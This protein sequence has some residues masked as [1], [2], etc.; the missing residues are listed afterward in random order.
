MTELPQRNAQNPQIKYYAN[1]GIWP[2]NGV[3]IQ[4]S[5]VMKAIPLRPEEIDGTA[6]VDGQNNKYDAVNASE[7]ECPP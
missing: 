7:D 2:T 5:A 4:T 1:D 3:G 6:I